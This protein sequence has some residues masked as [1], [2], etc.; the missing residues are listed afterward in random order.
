M[1]RSER[2]CMEIFAKDALPVIVNGVIALGL[3]AMGVAIDSEISTEFIALFVASV[4]MLEWP[5]RLCYGD[6]S[7]LCCDALIAILFALQRGRMSP[8]QLE[9]LLGHITWAAL[10]RREVLSILSACYK[11]ADLAGTAPVRLWPS[12]A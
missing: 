12:V 8:R 5:L 6:R 9:R 7:C 2:S 4:L 3:L 11:F 1:Q 10:V